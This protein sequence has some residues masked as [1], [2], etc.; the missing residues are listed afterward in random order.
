METYA[1]GSLYRKILSRCGKCETCLDSAEKK[2]PCKKPNYDRIWFLSYKHPNGK[3]IRESSKATNKVVADRLL[4]QRCEAIDAGSYVHMK[5]AKATSFLEFKEQ[6][7][8]TSKKNIRPSW[9]PGKRRVFKSIDAFFG[10]MTLRDITPQLIEEYR[11]K[12]LKDRVATRGTRLNRLVQPSTINRELSALNALLNE[13]VKKDVLVVNPCKKCSDLLFSEDGRERQRDLESD[14]IKRLLDAAEYPLKQILTIAVHTGMRRSEISGLR[15]FDITMTDERNY[16]S[17]RGTVTKNGEPRKV[18]MNKTVK[19]AIVSIRKTPNSD[20]LFPGS[21]LKKPWD[22][23]KPFEA[24]VKKAGLN[25]AGKEKLCFHHLRHTFC[26]QLGLLGYNVTTIMD[27]SGHKT[28]EIALRYTHANEA[29]SMKA[30]ERLE[31]G[32]GDQK[33]RNL[34]P[35]R[36]PFVTESVTSDASEPIFDKI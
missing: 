4:K 18:L 12:R 26:T 1:K 31:A 9:M 14:E 33:D 2:K 8:L 19:D 28:Y 21:D 10:R 5:K 22:F 7:L 11:N 36:V 20:L 17:L 34:S 23:R 15:W 16:I 6:Y 25:V 30:L 29:H 3:R 13:A 27:L 24:A 32:I 35:N